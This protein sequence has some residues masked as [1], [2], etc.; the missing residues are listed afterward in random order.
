MERRAI[1]Q[2]QAREKQEF[3]EELAAKSA[4][5]LGY[6]QLNERVAAETKPE[7]ALAELEI[8]PF[9]TGS[10]KEYQDQMVRQGQPGLVRYGETFFLL[11]S[12]IAALTFAA[13]LLVGVPA[14]KTFIWK[15]GRSRI[16]TPSARPKK[17]H[18]LILAVFQRPVG[19][20]VLPSRPFFILVIFLIPY[21]R[22]RSIMI[23]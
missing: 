11:A 13:L 3:L 4:R 22:V 20:E 23:S 14:A 8:E 21:M 5:L 7:Q 19:R 1:R 18:S 6:G 10:V 2:A 16:S 9:T 15:F 17:P 12:F